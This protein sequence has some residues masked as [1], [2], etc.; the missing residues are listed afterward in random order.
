[1]ERRIF[2]AKYKVDEPGS[3]S[4]ITQRSPGR[5][6]LF[7]EKDDYLYM[8]RLIKETAQK[9]SL[10]IFA[11]VLMPNHIHLLLQQLK[12]NLSLAMKNL[13]ERYAG[14]FN[15]K[16]ER[17]GHVFCGRFRQ[18]VCLDESYLFAITTYI[19]NNPVRAGLV[20]DPLDYQWSSCRPYIMSVAEETFLDYKY[21]LNMLSSNIN[22]A[23][24][25]YKD[26]LK[27][28]L[29]LKVGNVLE[30]K[31]AMD[32]YQLNL[33]RIIR[34]IFVDKIEN[35]NIFNMDLDKKLEE[36]EMKK[37]FKDLQTIKARVYMVQQLL[38][39]GYISEAIAER[40][41]ISKKTVSRY[42]K[43]VPK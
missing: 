16:Y 13:F 5:E 29:R 34:T 8:L 9:F 11:F 43:I 32:S 38:A 1:M 25:I 7:L 17:K 19:H 39:R 21:V 27:E 35:Q 4:H 6:Q 37:D 41:G 26:I 12:K 28:A 30:E 33:Q 18:S 14:V 24:E 3:I 23:R 15:I 2:R 42:Q 40:L 20:T 31:K 10:K 22:R 36:L